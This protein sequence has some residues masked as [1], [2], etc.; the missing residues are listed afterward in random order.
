MIVTRGGGASG[1]P[2]YDLLDLHEVQLSLDLKVLKDFY[3]S[4]KVLQL[5]NEQISPLARFRR[6]KELLWRQ[7]DE[8]R[9]IRLC[10]RRLYSAI[11]LDKFFQLAVSLTAASV[12]R[13]FNFITST[14]IGNEVNA[15]HGDY[16]AAFTR[17]GISS[18]LTD[19]IMATFIASSILLDAYPPNMHRRFD[20]PPD[21]VQS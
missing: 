11:H 3:S 16:L 1:S 8:M 15:D 18:G 17:L 13:P 4:I 14:R 2:T 7:I 21:E 19:E 9:N 6:L 5:A 10:H 12:L 20:P